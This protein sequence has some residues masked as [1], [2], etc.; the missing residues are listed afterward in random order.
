MSEKY[1]IKNISNLVVVNSIFAAIA[2]LL[3]VFVLQ[4]TSLNGKIYLIAF[5]FIPFFLFALTAERIIDAVDE[6]NTKKHVAYML[7]YNIGVI[8]LFFG[9]VLIIHF[10]SEFSLTWSLIIA[11][12]LSIPWIVDSWWLL[13]ISEGDNS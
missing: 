9:I 4:D 1:W 7:L 2:G 13:R 10:K 5:S 11:L 6:S 3:L 8:L 12:I